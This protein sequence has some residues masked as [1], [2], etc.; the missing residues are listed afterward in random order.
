MAPSVDNSKC[1][2]V[3][4][5]YYPG[6]DKTI[7]MSM[8]WMQA[9]IWLWY[10]TNYVYNV[11]LIKWYHILFLWFWTCVNRLFDKQ[12]QAQMYEC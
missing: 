10:V 6:Y 3:Y 5:A 12:E 1:I 11:R 4:L 8:R 9:H 7:V 2:T